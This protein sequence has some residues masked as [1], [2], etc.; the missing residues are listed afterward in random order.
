M[1][2]TDDMNRQA[3]ADYV[4]LSAELAIL[5]EAGRR[6]EETREAQ[7]RFFAGDRTLRTFAEQYAAEQSAYDPLTDT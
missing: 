5:R 3:I 4:R 2:R 7:R 1:S 6:L